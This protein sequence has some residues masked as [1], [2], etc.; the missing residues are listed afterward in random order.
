MTSTPHLT[1]RKTSD[2]DQL[3]IANENDF[4]AARPLALEKSAVYF[5]ARLAEEIQ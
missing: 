2:L 1:G 4:L 3:A 5:A